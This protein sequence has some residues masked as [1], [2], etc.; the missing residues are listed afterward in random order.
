MTLES[1]EDAGWVGSLHYRMFRPC[2][3]PE[4]EPDQRK[5][6]EKKEVGGKAAQP[7]SISCYRNHNI[8]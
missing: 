8:Y 6:E 7:Q 4:H 2:P 3:A 1:L 5:I